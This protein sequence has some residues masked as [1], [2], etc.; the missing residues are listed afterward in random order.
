MTPLD[1]FKVN[2]PADWEVTG[3]GVVM[4][5]E[6]AVVV[7]WCDT[8]DYEVRVTL[9][10]CSL[11]GTSRPDRLAWVV[12]GL[13]RDVLIEAALW[14]PRSMEVAFNKLFSEWP[15]WVRGVFSETFPSAAAQAIETL[16]ERRARADRLGRL[17]DMV[18]QN[19]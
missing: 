5:G 19:V 12:T 7:E 17:S 2:Y 8:G 6:L 15:D 13:L 18:E 10:E 1:R 14:M 9:W 3:A 11:K 16:G 4:H